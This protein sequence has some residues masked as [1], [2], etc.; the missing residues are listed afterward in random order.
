M[1]KILRNLKIRE[2]SSV[3][4]G[5]GDGVKIVL[6]KRL[7]E[8]RLDADEKADRHNRLRK[9]FTAALRKKSEYDEE[10]SSPGFSRDPARTGPTAADE[11]AGSAER[12]NEDRYEDREEPEQE[13]DVI[14]TSVIPPRLQQMVNAVRTAAPH[15]SEQAIVHF[16]LHTARGR[17]VAE[18]LATHITKK[19][20][21]MSRIERLQ[22]LA[23]RGG[24]QLVAKALLEK[25]DAME[26][27]EFEFTELMIAEAT[28]KKQSFEAY[29]TDPANIDIRKA[30]ALT[31]STLVA[32]DS[33][34]RA[35]EVQPVSVEA[36]RT[37][38]ETDTQE[39]Y[40]QLMEMAEELAASGKYQSVASAFSALFSDQKNAELAA[41]AHNRPNA[42]NA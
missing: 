2:I 38:V 32:K 31:K 35:V 41:R 15:V 18:H 12:R 40:E 36:G 6:M 34:L 9:M 3:D 28:R 1:A 27:S 22:A 23:K 37:D 10:M 13:G 14:A 7:D 25:G 19:E 5:A 4:K 30:H 20:E 26:I 39:A 33:L 24:V 16:L 42:A 21:P 17:D 8:P 11:D 29:F